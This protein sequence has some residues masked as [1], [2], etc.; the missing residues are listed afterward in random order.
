MFWTFLFRNVLRAIAACIFRHSNFQRWREYA[1]F[2]TFWLGNVLRA[3]TASTFSTSELPKVARTC[4]VLY[5]LTWK[6]ASRHNGAH[7]F[8]ILTAKSGPDLV[9]FM[10]FDF[11]MYFVR[12]R[13]IFF[14]ILIS[15]SDPN[16]LYFLY[17]NF[18]MCFAPQRRVRFHHF[19]FQKRS[20]PDVVYF[21]L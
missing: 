11:E 16:L 8:N 3:T 12:H 21:D 5:I 2:C 15:K 14:N 19:I 9:Y 10:Y 4:A 17:F 20:E 13:R 18:K 6:C 7:F 1:V